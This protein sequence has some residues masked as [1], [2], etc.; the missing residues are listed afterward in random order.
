MR[1]ASCSSSREA[2][3]TRCGVGSPIGDFRWVHGD[4]PPPK[5][6]PAGRVPVLQQR[7]GGER[8]PC[9]RRGDASARRSARA[10]SASRASR[11]HAHALAVDPDLATR[12]HHA[13]RCAR[14]RGRAARRP[15][16]SAARAQRPGGSLEDDLRLRLRQVAQQEP[17]RVALRRATPCA[18]N[19]GSARPCRPAAPRAVAPASVRDRHTGR[20]RRRDPRSRSARV[21]AVPGRSARGSRWSRSGTRPPRCRR[22]RR[23]AAGTACRPPRAP[24]PPRRGSPRGASAGRPERGRDRVAG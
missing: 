11:G 16:R 23:R 20:R 18:A 7:L 1:T 15:L 3:R 2:I 13:R 14:V 5:L 9:D 24:T 4:S 19:R 8:E 22:G 21:R 10:R 12:V 6:Q 17:L